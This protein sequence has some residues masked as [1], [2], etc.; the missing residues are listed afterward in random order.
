[1]GTLWGLPFFDA[2]V[3]EKRILRRG[4]LGQPL[5]GGSRDAAVRPSP[6]S[7]AT[8][9]P[10]PP[11]VTRSRTGAA[12]E[13][14][15]VRPTLRVCKPCDTRALPMAVLAR[16]QGS[17][18][19]GGDGGRAGGRPQ[20]VTTSPPSRRTR[21][22]ASVWRAGPVAHFRHLA[23][24]ADGIVLLIAFPLA[25]EA[26]TE[27]LPADLTRLYDPEVYIAPAL[28]LALGTLF[29]LER[30]GAYE[31]ANVLR[32]R[33]MIVTVAVAIG[34]AL[35][36]VATALF[37]FKLSYVSRLFVGLYAMTGAVLLLA[38]RLGF[39]RLAMRLRESGAAAA[40]VLL[41]GD[42][43]SADQMARGL[44]EETLF[45]ATIVARLSVETMARPVA[46]VRQA[47]GSAE[48]SGPVPLSP[49]SEFLRNEAIDEVAVAS[50]GLAEG[51]LE[52]LV[53]AC[54]REGVAL[55]VSAGALAVGLERAYLSPIGE[56]R[57]LSVNPQRHSA[58]GRAVKRGLDLV[59]APVLIVLLA[60]AWII[61]AIAIKLDSPGP[62]FFVQERIGLNKRRF[63]MIK[64]RSMY[65]GSEHFHA[66][67][68]PL[69]EADGPIFKL[70][71][72]PRV[73]RVGRW[74]RR[75]D[76][77]EVPQ[78]LNVLRGDMSFIGPRPMLP[79][80]ITGFEPWQRKRFSM[81]PGITGLWQVSNRL[82]QSFLDGLRA[83]LEY[84]DRWSLRL[85]LEI[86]VRTIPAILRDRVAP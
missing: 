65:E 75:F 69:N 71:R 9:E 66:A 85:D 33:G 74:L 28:L 6:R 24:L 64:F 27:W 84:I 86:A 37:V 20:G 23:Q 49:I 53:E 63:P 77:D 48:L 50:P 57:V 45:G 17:L 38:V 58:W 59:V 19:P 12:G 60:P 47:L 81:Q 83:D 18:A 35:V 67:L 70:R 79:G 55:H 76:I 11:S 52:H 1:L 62:V 14:G 10:T 41:I 26:K 39:R 4:A 61:A 7:D 82:G 5:A 25:Y 54:D 8:I 15:P 2:L 51:E 46:V 72:D 56:L 22:R 3:D 32:L 16:G 78:L 34:Q 44:A 31:A 21:S 42:G 13:A 73:T 30:R 40:R 36:L 80:E 29:G 68:T 43:E